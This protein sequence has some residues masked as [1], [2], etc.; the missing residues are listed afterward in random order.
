MEHRS[1]NF[2]FSMWPSCLSTFNTQW[3]H[4]APTYC[5]IHTHLI[6]SILRCTFFS[7]FNMSEIRV[8][9]TNIWPFP[10]TV[11][12]SV[13]ASPFLPLG[14]LS[15]SFFTSFPFQANPESPYTVNLGVLCQ[16][17]MLQNRE[18]SL[19]LCLALISASWV[20][21]T[22]MDSS[23]EDGKTE[24]GNSPGTQPFKELF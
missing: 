14:D 10:E 7:H 12:C 19:C 4:K 11:N 8:H 22:I 16:G 3:H 17:N 6:S 9:L 1:I 21:T 15:C 2:H 23:F 5:T 24:S 18:V 13:T 20:S